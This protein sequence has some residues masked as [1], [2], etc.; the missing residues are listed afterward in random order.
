MTEFQDEV[1]TD[2]VFDGE[3]DSERPRH[4]EGI[5]DDETELQARIVGFMAQDQRDT[6]AT[7]DWYNRLHSNPPFDPDGMCQKVCRYARNIAAKFASA[8]ESQDGTPSEHRVHNIADLRRGMVAYF[9]TVGD[10]NPFGHIVTIV[11]RV[12]GVDRNKLESLIV[13]TNSVKANELVKVRGNYFRDHWGDSFTFGATWLNGQELKLPARAP[14]PEPVPSAK[15]AK[16]SR[17]V[18][19]DHISLQIQDDKAQI[20]ADINNIFERAREKKVQAITGTEAFGP[21]V[22]RFLESA[23]ERFQYRVERPAG[24]DC[25]IAVRKSFIA[26]NFQ[27]NWEK[28]IEGGDTHRDLG[29]FDV[30]FDTDQ[31]GRVSIFA[32][33]LLTARQPNAA[34]KN[35]RIVAATEARARVL[36]KGT[37]LAVIGADKNK[38]DRFHDTF[39]KSNFTSVADELKKYE[40]THPH[41]RPI[42]VFGTWDLDGRVEARDIRVLDDTEFKL[43]GD[44]FL[45]EVDLDIEF[46]N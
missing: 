6:D 30:S 25:W 39:P 16:T 26:G 38:N 19:F 37:N 2:D 7:L 18:R 46:L 10:S 24:Q 27:V 8:K 12:K 22:N 43:F 3:P 41:G 23:G 45:V 35:L 33:H 5:Q 1:S 40:P 9:D 44:H 32:E 4:F 14:V 21:R 28:I 13:W 15:P 11:G 31:I 20:Q 42:D 29:V 17:R 34:A 36:A